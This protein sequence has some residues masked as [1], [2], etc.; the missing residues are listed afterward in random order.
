MPNQY[1]INS[2]IL[3]EIGE[4]DVDTDMKDFLKDVLQFEIDIVDQG[5]PE[6]RDA[7]L[8]FINRRVK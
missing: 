8:D 4:L 2:R 3:K 1:D 7:Y 5:R 6:Y